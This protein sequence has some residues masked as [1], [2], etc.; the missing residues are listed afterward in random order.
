[1]SNKSNIKFVVDALLFLCMAALAGIGFLMKYVLLP[2]SEAQIKYATK[3]HLSWLSLD[4]HEWGTI[5]LVIA[6]VLAGLL[7]LHIVLNWKQV[8]TMFQKL[9]GGQAPRR[10]ISVVF[11]TIGLVFLIFPFVVEP[12]IQEF[13]RGGGDGQGSRGGRHQTVQLPQNSS[14]KIYPHSEQGG[15]NSV[16]DTLNS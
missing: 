14:D 11:V 10:I 3:V 4:R 16:T 13:Q 7:I 5:H 1:M 9:I 6:L 15:H 12:E 2:G 8:L